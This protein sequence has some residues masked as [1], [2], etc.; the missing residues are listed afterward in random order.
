MKKFLQTALV[1]VV[2]L[3]ISCNDGADNSEAASTDTA[4]STAD[5]TPAPAPSAP[6]MKTLQF[7]AANEVPPNNSTATGTADVTYNKETK[8]LS[9]SV[10]YSGLTGP[11]TMAHIH[12]TAP[13]GVNSGVKHDLTSVL[14]KAASGSF[15]DSVKIGDGIVEDSLLSGFYYFN[16]HTDKNK[17]G[18][19]R[20]Q[21]EF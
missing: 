19:I 10:N 11:A 18:E 7:S 20:A 12:G 5:A 8:M 4:S 21:I 15:V 14:K 2:S 16:I 13:K 3:C 9:Y 6:L 17:G 1:G